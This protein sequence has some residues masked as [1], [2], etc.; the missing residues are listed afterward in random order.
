MVPYGKR[1]KDKRAFKRIYANIAPGKCSG[2]LS[3]TNHMAVNIRAISLNRT[4]SFDGET[5]DGGHT[6]VR[7]PEGN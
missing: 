4:S 3:I 2:Q 7:H 1:Q 6:A 5:N